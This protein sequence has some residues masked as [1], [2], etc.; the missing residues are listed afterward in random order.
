MGINHR[1]IIRPEYFGDITRVGDDSIGQPARE[2]GL[3]DCARAL[4]YQ[5]GHCTATGSED[6]KWDFF[7]HQVFPFSAPVF[8]PEPA[9]RPEIQTVIKQMA[10]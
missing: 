7:P 5:V 4:L 6:K 9:Q 1:Q 8:R 3:P 2:R 10:A